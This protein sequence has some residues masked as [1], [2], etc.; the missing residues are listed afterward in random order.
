MKTIASLVSAL[1]VLTVSGMAITNPTKPNLTKPRLDLSQVVTISGTIHINGNAAK[2]KEIKVSLSSQP[3]SSK[4]P[5]N[6]KANASVTTMSAKECG[7]TLFVPQNALGKTGYINV[8][9]PTGT[10]FV[11]GN[12]KN[13]ISIPQTGGLSNINGQVKL[14]G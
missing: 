7:Y 6:F 12:W 2:C 11:P 10:Y 5:S 13:P 4:F 3:I 9:V 14:I 1:T 8:D